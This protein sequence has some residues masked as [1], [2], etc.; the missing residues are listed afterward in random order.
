MH[1]SLEEQDLLIALPYDDDGIHFCGY[2]F[3]L[4]ITGGDKVTCI[5]L[6]TIDSE[7]VK[8]DEFQEASQALIAQFVE[9]DELLTAQYGTP[10]RYASHKKET[11]EIWTVDILTTHLDENGA[12]MAYSVWGNVYMCL[13]LDSEHFQHFSWDE[14]WDGLRTKLSLY[15]YYR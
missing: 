15:Y 11:V 9:I 3:R 4:A 5:D 8:E 1:A 12:Y 2:P 10:T 14:P 13:W 7:W 6:L